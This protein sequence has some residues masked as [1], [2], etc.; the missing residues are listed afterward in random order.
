MPKRTGTASAAQ[1]AREVQHLVA[2]DRVL[3]R[4]R[5][6]LGLFL[7]EYTEYMSRWADWNE[8]IG[9]TVEVA[10]GAPIV[11][12]MPERY[13]YERTQVAD[14]PPRLVSPGDDGEEAGWLAPPRTKVVGAWVNPDV[15]G[16]EPVSPRNRRSLPLDYALLARAHDSW[17]T[18]GGA[19]VAELPIFDSGALQESADAPRSKQVAYWGTFMD[20]AVTPKGDGEHLAGRL[21]AALVRVR[22]DLERC[23][24]TG[25]PAVATRGTEGVYRAAS[26]F[27]KGAS[28]WLRSATRP[29]RKTKRV[30]SRN[31]DGMK[32]YSVADVEQWRPD[33]LPVG[34]E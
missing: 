3:A 6:Q 5:E 10:H 11:G 32:C 22:R 1:I 4:F 29:D 26:W 25:T 27:R 15:R 13:R 34:R 14:G 21:A 16:P 7:H 9:K 23:G 8:A 19:L 33:L 31:I 18:G 2:D 17:S 24:I 12:P 30:R 20:W 28:A